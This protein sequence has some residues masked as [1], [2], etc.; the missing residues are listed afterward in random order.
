VR[1]L[2]KRDTFPSVLGSSWLGDR[3]G[4]WSCRW[5]VSV[6]QRNIC[7]LMSHATLICTLLKQKSD[8]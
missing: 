2:V 4:I 1:E 8:S 5:H 3:K 7:G 6:A